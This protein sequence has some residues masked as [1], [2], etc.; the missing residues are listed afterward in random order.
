IDR[1]NSGLA[2]LRDSASKVADLQV[3]LKQKQVIVNEKQIATEELMQRVGKE[4]NI[5]QEQSK[6]AALE[7][8]KTNALVE[9]V[10]QYKDAC[11]KDLM[12]AEPLVQAA[13]ASLNSLKKQDL[14]ELKSLNK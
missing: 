4:T 8:Q 13:L 1:L 14:Q 3:Q 7:E 6:I 2:R 9:E 11:H 12:E 10:Q 5:V